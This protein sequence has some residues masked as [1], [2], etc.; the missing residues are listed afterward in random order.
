M[1]I[2]GV[3]TAEGGRLGLPPLIAIADGTGGIAIRVPD[4]IATPPRGST[5]R[6]RG[7]LA[8]PYGQLELR[9]AATGF[10]VTGHGSLPTPL[11]LTAAQ[12]GESTEG[13]L[14]EITGTVAAAPAKGTSGDLTVDLVDAA[15][16]TFRV[17]S[18]GS[19]GVVAADLA[20]GRT[21]RL[22]GIVG[23]RASRKGA[24]DGY[25]RRIRDRGD[26]V[27]VAAP[28]VPGASGAPA[29]THAI[30]AVRRCPTARSS[31]SR[32]PSPPVRTS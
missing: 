16:T 32:R 10:T 22:T 4:G 5:V 2:S 6:V 24:L 14:A 31:R 27:A 15:G 23:Q 29:T 8:D 11:Q 20:K 13:R 12:L 18:D 17:L 3:V 9:P 28:A 25:R 26:I 21:V 30:S 7:A 19:S 1:T